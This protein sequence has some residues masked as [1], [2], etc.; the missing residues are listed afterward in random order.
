L[1]VLP[2][3]RVLG[4]GAGRPVPVTPPAAGENPA[5][6]AMLALLT[7]EGQPDATFGPAGYRLLDF[8]GKADFFWAGAAAA[9]KRSVAVVGI[10]SG[11]DDSD[12]DD[13]VLVIVT[14]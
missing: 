13:G 14:P 9:D 8:G 2:D 7:A 11:V 12:D 1:I 4:I 3:K 10:A 5:S 6:D